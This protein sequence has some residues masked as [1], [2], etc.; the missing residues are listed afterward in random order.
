MENAT[1]FRQYAN[2]LIEF[3]DSPDIVAAYNDFEDLTN[4]GYS[5]MEAFD[6]VIFLWK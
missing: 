2:R 5:L 3:I 4:N 6:I 1:D